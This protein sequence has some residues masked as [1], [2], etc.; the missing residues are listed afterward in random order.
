M[1]VDADKGAVVRVYVHQCVLNMDWTGLHCVLLLHLFSRM[2][3][4]ADPQE[5]ASIEKRRMSERENRDYVA[6]DLVRGKQT[7]QQDKLVLI[8]PEKN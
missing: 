4:T 6:D 5:K 8:I 3:V 7:A 1:Y 2:R